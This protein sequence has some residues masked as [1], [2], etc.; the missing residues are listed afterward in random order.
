MGPREKGADGAGVA[1]DRGV[2]CPGNEKLYWT[3][4][5]EGRQGGGVVRK[6]LSLQTGGPEQIPRIHLRKSWGVAGTTGTVL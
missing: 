1:G 5:E 6:G 2:G 4:E 3:A